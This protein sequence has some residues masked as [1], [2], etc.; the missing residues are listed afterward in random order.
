MAGFLQGCGYAPFFVL[1]LALVRVARNLSR[2]SR[3]G[4]VQGINGVLDIYVTRWVEHGI[5]KG[6]IEGVI[7]KKLEIESQSSCIPGRNYMSPSSFGW[8]VA[9]E[10]GPV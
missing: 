7:D 10:L 3:A 8:S 5:K 2:V 4:V 9:V 6:R 1:P